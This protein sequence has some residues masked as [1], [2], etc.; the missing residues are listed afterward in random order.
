[1]L[2]IFSKRKMTH[3]PVL[4]LAMIGAGAYVARLWWGDLRHARA[5]APHPAALP[6]ATPAPGRAHVIAIAG[7]LFL[8]AVE[9][10]GEIRLH[11]AGQ[12]STMTAL[13]AAYTLV[14][15]VIEEIIFRGYLVAN[16]WGAAVRWLGIVGASVLF[17]LLH[18]FLWQWDEHFALT[19]TTKGAFSTA[20]VFLASLWFYTVRFA[21]WNPAQSLAPCIAAH[22]AKNLGVI[23]IKAAQGFLVGWW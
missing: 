22:A 20:M 13:F 10:G 3:N 4:L 8:L 14:A 6:G 7:A 1:M 9:T 21:R 19:L 5:G 17:A 12:Q 2:G 18:P 11:L 15:A 16:R 23:A